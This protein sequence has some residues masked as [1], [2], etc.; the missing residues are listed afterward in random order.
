MRILQLVTLSEMGGAQQVCLRI[1]LGAKR[2]GHHVAVACAPGG[3]LVER[4]R[5]AGIQV[6]ALPGLRRDIDFTQDLGTLFSI[7]DL[8][9]SGEFDLVH[10]HSS[11]AGLLGRIAS[12]LAGVPA[13]IW[14]RTW[15][16]R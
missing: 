9:R 6:Y 2:A 12:R 16:G 3:W 5:R 1:V 13:A 14:R 4:L 15:M 7:R 11:K 8:L 10:C